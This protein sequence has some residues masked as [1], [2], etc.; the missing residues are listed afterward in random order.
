MNWL[1]LSLRLD[2][3]ISQC[4]CILSWHFFLLI[5]SQHTR[6]FAVP[7][8]FGFMRTP[9]IRGFFLT[10]TDASRNHGIHLHPHP[11]CFGLFLT[12]GSRYYRNLL[13]THRKIRPFVFA[14]TKSRDVAVSL[15]LPPFLPS[16]NVTDIFYSHRNPAF[17]PFATAASCA[18]CVPSCVP[19]SKSAVPA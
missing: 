6:F 15:F 2:V 9:A 12:K 4:L 16:T 13:K 17:P 10:S 11:V 14:S 5:A 3:S 8:D 1:R 7:R 18:Y 19:R